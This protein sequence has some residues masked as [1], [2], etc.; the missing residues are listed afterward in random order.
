MD[1]SGHPDLCVE[2]RGSLP[3]TESH[4]ESRGL[5]RPFGKWFGLLVP[6]WQRGALKQIIDV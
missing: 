1:F 6:F 2:V 5:V 4:D 3:R